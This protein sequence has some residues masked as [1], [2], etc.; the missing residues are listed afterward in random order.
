MKPTVINSLF[1]A[2]LL[3]GLAFRLSLLRYVFGDVY[4]L[5]PEGWTVLTLR[6]G[7]FF[8]FLAVLNEVVW[9]T[10]STDF[11][12]AFKVW[13]TMPITVIFAA[14]QLPV[15]T[16]YAPDHKVHEVVP[17]MDPLP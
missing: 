14:L 7:L 15:L 2:V 6:W 8:F 11:W 9:R 4:K 12:V 13:A 3:G 10:Q 17:P 5:K 16:R 1:G